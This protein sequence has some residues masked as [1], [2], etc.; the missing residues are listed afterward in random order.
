MIMKISG[1]SEV[2]RSLRHC[3]PA[4]TKPTTSHHRSPGGERRGKRKRLTIFLEVTR[5]GHRQSDERFNCFKGNVG[6]TSEGRGG[7]NIGFSGAHKL[8]S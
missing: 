6:E 5:E 8:P 1:R 2:L 4:L 3:L 7:G